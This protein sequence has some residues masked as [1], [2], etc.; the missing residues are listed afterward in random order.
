MMIAEESTSWPLITYPVEAGGLGFNFKW[1]MGWMNDSL[2]YMGQDPFFRKGVHNNLTFSMTYAFSENFI[3]PLSHDE[4]VHGKKSLLSKMPGEY[5]IKFANLR[6]Y[7]GY[8]YA[9]PGKKLLF[10]GAEFGQFIEWNEEQELNW[11]LLSF[12]AHAKQ[13]TYTKALSQF[14]LKTPA[15]W[16]LDVSW[17]GFEWADVD[18]NTNNVLAF[19]RRDKDGN[20]ILAVS[21]FSSVYHPDYKIGVPRRGNYTE[22]FSSDAKEFGGE[23][24]TNGTVSAKSGKMHGQKYHISL[25]LPPFST[26]YFFKKKPQAKTSQET[27][28]KNNQTTATKN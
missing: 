8:M 12:E 27:K 14:Y 22:V 21:N 16:E 6:A 20:M 2:L 26:L 17:E 25:A 7:L 23:G 18:D 28:A 5:A 10:M 1:N 4:V 13:K 24:I 19:F 11:N 9:H 15:L 3:L